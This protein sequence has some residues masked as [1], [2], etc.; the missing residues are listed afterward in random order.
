MASYTVV[1]E[2]ISIMAPLTESDK[3]SLH[4][5][6]SKSVRDA[7]LETVPAA[8]HD[9]MTD[10]VDELIKAHHAECTTERERLDSIVRDAVQKTTQRHALYLKIIIGL[11]AAYGLIDV[12][13]ATSLFGLL[14]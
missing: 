11:G 6:I 8:V 5:T 4:A 2:G 3:R 7:V 14:Q 10:R 12:S 13:K 1:T 9:A